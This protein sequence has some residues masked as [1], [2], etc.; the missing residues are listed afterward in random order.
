MMVCS[1]TRVAGYRWLALLAVLPLWG[2][3]AGCSMGPPAATVTVE[4]M[5]ISSTAVSAGLVKL[6]GAKE[7]GWLSP[8]DV[9]I[10]A[11]ALADRHWGTL[12]K[13]GETAV[14][15]PQTGHFEPQALPTL[16]VYGG[17]GTVEELTAVGAGD[18]DRVDVLLPAGNSSYVI[19]LRGGRLTAIRASEYRST[20][21]RPRE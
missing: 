6:H 1:H 7:E 11:P 17:D 19:T 8:A 5:N 10:H 13:P 15:G 16:R 12:I 4:V 21:Q 20:D 3:L 9:V 18:P 14:L 2:G